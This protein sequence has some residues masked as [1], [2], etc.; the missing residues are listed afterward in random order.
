MIAVSGWAQPG[1][2]LSRSSDSRYAKP[3]GGNSG[4]ALSEPSL[5]PGWAAPTAAQAAY[6]F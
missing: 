1:W 5:A 3:T 4:Q 2:S 6:A